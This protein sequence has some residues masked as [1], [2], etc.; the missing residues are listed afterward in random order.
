MQQ[1]KVPLTTMHMAARAILTKVM[2]L[3]WPAG[4]SSALSIPKVAVPLLCV[5]VRVIAIQIYTQLFLK[6]HF[7]EC[8]SAAEK[9][10]F[11]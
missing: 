2:V 8:A 1:W 9:R 3:V 6:K 7:C 5:Q 11:L 10:M 4:S